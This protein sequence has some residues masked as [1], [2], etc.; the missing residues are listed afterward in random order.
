MSRSTVTPPT[1]LSRNRRFLEPA[2]GRIPWNTVPLATPTSSVDSP[3][4]ANKKMY[5]N[6][7]IFTAYFLV[8]EQPRNVH[9]R[10][11]WFWG[12]GRS[13]NQSRL[14]DQVFSKVKS[15]P[16]K[17]SSETSHLDKYST[18]DH[19]LVLQYSRWPYIGRVI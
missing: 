14:I 11:R 6:C 8:F 18:L 9:Q 16:P 12:G 13:W 5:D 4:F 19:S 7:I 17:K 2:Y 3:S 1:F 15:P 10:N